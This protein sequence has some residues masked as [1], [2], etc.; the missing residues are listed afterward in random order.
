MVY[1][2]SEIL[3]SHKKNEILPSVMTWIDI[4]DVML[5]ELSQTKKDKYYMISLICGIKIKTN[6]TI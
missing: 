5:S 6:G 1:I 2:H 4:D 3:L